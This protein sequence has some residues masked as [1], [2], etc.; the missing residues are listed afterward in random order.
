M[1]R[2]S[3]YLPF[4]IALC[5]V[6]LAEGVIAL[7]AVSGWMDAQVKNVLKRKQALVAQDNPR[8][9]DVLALGSSRTHN[10]FAANAFEASAEKPINA[11]NMGLPTGDYYIYSL[12]LKDFVRQY[13]KPRLVMLDASEFLFNRN[14]KSGYNTLYL[15]TL[16]QQNPELAQSIW[17]SPFLDAEDKK[18][19][20]LSG[21]SGLYRY[22]VLLRPKTLAKM[23]LKGLPVKSPLYDGW[24]PLP[25]KISIMSSEQRAIEA[26]ENTARKFYQDYPAIDTQP[27]EALVTYC[28]ESG[29]PVVMVRWPLHPTF[30]R[31]FETYPIQRDYDA[32]LK[33]IATQ[34]DVA[35]VDLNTQA[36]LASDGQ[37]FRDPSHLSESGAKT[38]SAILARQVFDK[39]S[40]NEWLSAQH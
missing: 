22:R 25:D 12:V 36:Q 37:N 35:L 9:M 24:E 40:P 7:P 21:L 17:Q 1:K 23:A 39:V 33:R 20:V 29:I 15:S 2:P 13:G 32:L 30:V 11:F 10:G 4:L 34:Y 19:I 5:I 3:P 28:R 16:I 26:A 14:L 8:Q 38:F 27:F 6:L 18:E 31:T